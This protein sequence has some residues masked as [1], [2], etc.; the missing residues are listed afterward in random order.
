LNFQDFIGGDQT[1]PKEPAE[2]ILDPVIPTPTPTPKDEQPDLAPKKEENRFFDLDVFIKELYVKTATR[3][4][5]N[6]K[7][8]KY[9][10]AYDVSSSCITNII[11]KLRS[12]PVK[13]YADRWAP[14]ALRGTIGKAI[15]E[16]IQEN[17]KQ[18][19]EEELS[20]KVPSIRFSGRFDG[21]IHNNVL[22][23]IK[24]LPYKEYCK[25][26]KNKTPRIDDFYQTLSYKYILENHLQES[27]TH[28]EPTRSP[29]PTQNNYKI[30]F[31]Q[32]IYVA[33]DIMAADVDSLGDALAMVDHVKK[34]LNSKH[35]TF[36]FMSNLLIDLRSIDITAHMNYITSKIERVNY[37]MDNNLNVRA[38]DEF[39]ENGKCFF[40][41]FSN[42]CPHRKQ[43]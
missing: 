27:K 39:I 30:D 22:L 23:E 33:H 38:D 15:H 9:M 34:L 2:K 19:T 25:I 37:Y 21:M 6:I 43:K 35:N 10:S 36:Y 1:K 14:I 32:F 3:N 5:L 11:H 4:E 24:S 16:F 29:K 40:C 28:N 17:T 7:N 41:L 13:N 42:G 12:T 31:I 8:Q 20:L 26:I 18:L